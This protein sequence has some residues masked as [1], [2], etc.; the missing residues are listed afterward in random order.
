VLHLH[1]NGRHLL[2]AVASL[3]GLKAVCL[4]DDRGIQPAFEFLPRAKQLAGN[5]PLI[6]GVNYA[7][8]R[9]SLDQH[10]L[11]G[12]VLYRVQQVPDVSTANRCTDAVRAY[13]T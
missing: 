13:R 10:R 4:S 6:V 5:L 1:G 2:P 12:G 3:R 8:F 9:D 7:A 11:P